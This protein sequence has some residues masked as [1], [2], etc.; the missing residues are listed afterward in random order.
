MIIR[1]VIFCCVLLFSLAQFASTQDARQNEN[2][3]RT[4]PDYYDRALRN[5]MKGF[6]ADIGHEWATLTHVYI[7]W[8]ELENNESD[9][10]DKIIEVSNEKFQD[11]PANN[12][13]F[14]PRVYLH[15]NDESEKYW[16]ED[17]IAGD[18]TSTQFQSRVLRLIDRL[19]VAWNNDPR[20]AFIELGIFGKWGEHHS[21]DP[22]PE[23]QKLVGEAFKKA[24]PDKKVSVRH[25]WSEFLGFGF[26]EY[27]DSW[28]HYQ[29]MWAHGHPISEQNNGSKLYL[30]NYIGGEVAYNWGPWHLQPG[31]SPTKSVSDPIH[32]DFIINSIRWLHG[33]QLRW[34]SNYDQTNEKARNGA[35]QIQK[36]FG[37]RFKLEEV[38]FNS[39][40]DNGLTVELTV[41]NEGSAIFYYNW[42]LEVALH[43]PESREIVWRETFKDVD[44]RS[45]EP[46]SNWTSPMERD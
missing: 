6:T 45:W 42:P 25:T 26:G 7:R 17:M 1:K 22:T 24:F 31:E 29:Q 39:K 28:A 36:V 8:N 44:I 37:Y 43:D 40:I 11:G 21:P 16:P 14:I 38:G 23:M 20:I 35:E 13:K 30:T 4:T 46:G 41:T 3:V 32:R 33:T 19:G 15:W 10:L 18:Y 12:V 27:W 5:P 2:F 34:I 9:G